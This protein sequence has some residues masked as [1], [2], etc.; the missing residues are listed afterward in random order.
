VLVELAV[1]RGTIHQ[2][3]GVSLGESPH[4]FRSGDEAQESD[5]RGACALERAHRRCSA[6]PSRQHRIEKEEV[7]L[8]RVTRD[9]EVVIDRFERVVIPIQTDVAYAR[10]GDEPINPFHHAK[11]RAEDGNERQLLSAHAS[12]DRLFE[13]CFHDGGL[14]RQIGGRFIRHQHRDL[15]DELL[16]DLRRRTAVAQNRD[17]V[18]NEWMRDDTERWERRGG[19]HGPEATIFAIM[20]EYQAVIVRLSR[21]TRD[22]EDALTDLLNERSRGGWEPTMMSQ[23]GERLTI[24]F[25]RPGN[26]D[27]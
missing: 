24:V 1:E 13:R 21:H 4:P 25:A 7:S 2:N 3:L 11:P 6:S 8:R 15:V 9:L 10:A 27:R 14:Q 16:E 5:A 23:D 20:K 19:V 12:S 22:D 26:G 18:L 17:L